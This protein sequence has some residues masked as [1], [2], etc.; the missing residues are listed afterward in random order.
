MLARVLR[1]LPPFALFSHACELRPHN[2]LRKWDSSESAARL[3]HFAA[4]QSWSFGIELYLGCQNH[5]PVISKVWDAFSDPRTCGHCA[6]I[7]SPF[8][9]PF[10]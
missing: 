3:R 5:R 8:C 4:S 10:T 2:P 7:V 1:T 9:A 6:P